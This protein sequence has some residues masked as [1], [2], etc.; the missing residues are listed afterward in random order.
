VKT[1]DSKLGV[2]IAP[3]IAVL[4]VA[5]VA[6]GSAPAAT[7]IVDEILVTPTPGPTL[8]LTPTVTPAPT[9]TSEPIPTLIP[10]FTSVSTL[11]STST[12][13]PTV[14][15]TT[16]QVPQRPLIRLRHD[17]QVY[18]GVAGTFCWPDGRGVLGKS[19][20]VVFGSL[21]GDE[22]PFPWE[23]LD[24][25]TA[26]PVAMGDSITVEIDADDQ[27]KGLQVAIF[28]SASKTAS[29]AAAQVIKLETGF[30]APF[31]VDVP[32]GQVPTSS[33]SPDSGTMGT[34]PTSSKW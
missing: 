24:T 19:G 13:T 28:D 14:N 3:L 33:A 4:M 26:V 30:T 8:T 17:G 11:T 5:A 9:V 22:T 29:A 12:P 1:I 23:V 34:S 21:C 18:K 16:I 10:T 15:P 6:C 31:A 7:Q 32:A 27:P 2:A 20:G 25:A